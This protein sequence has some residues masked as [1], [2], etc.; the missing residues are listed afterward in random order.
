MISYVLKN[1]FQKT[2]TIFRF[3][4]RMSSTVCSMSMP[5]PPLKT[6]FER[7]PSKIFE[8]ILLNA[9]S[10]N[11]DNN[12]WDIIYLCVNT[13]IDGP[14]YFT[15]RQFDTEIQA[16]LFYNIKYEIR[17]SNDEWVRAWQIIKISSKQPYRLH[18]KILQDNLKDVFNTDKINVMIDTD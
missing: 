9:S 6:R 15:C 16:L 13:I 3:R 2:N 17:R 4:H 11:P 1:N 10:N 5:I 12:D 14:G 18:N 7:I 8:T